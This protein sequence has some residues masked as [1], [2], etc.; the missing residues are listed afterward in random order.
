VISIL[1]ANI[2]ISVVIIGASTGGPSA[3]ST[4]LSSF[5]AD[6]PASIVVIQHIMENF[7]GP[8]ARRLEKK[9]QLCVKEGKNGDKLEHGNV[10]I[11]PTKKHL[12]FKNSLIRLDEGPTRNHF[13]PSIDVTMESA[14]QSF[15]KKV[16]GVVLTGA[17]SDGVKGLKAIK[18]AKGITIAQDEQS[19]VLYHM[20]RNAFKS[21]YV[22]YVL[23]L[24][25]IADKIKDLVHKK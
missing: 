5:P 11:A 16:M 21:G 14:V 1:K 19:S 20:P 6:F 7:S 12:V 22:D 25:D 9:C 18:E 13:K 4:I 23:P 17:G 8:L 10:Y 15:G 24:D 3:L 2:M